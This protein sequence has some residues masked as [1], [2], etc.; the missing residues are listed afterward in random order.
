MTKETGAAAGATSTGQTLAYGAGVVIV[1]LIALFGLGV[2]DGEETTEDSVQNAAQD[3][4]ETTPEV[5]AEQSVESGDATAIAADETVEA[6]AAAGADQQ[7][8]TDAAAQG[9]ADAAEETKDADAEAADSAAADTADTATETTAEEGAEATADMAPEATADEATDA[10]TPPSFDVVRVETDGNMQIAGEAAAG[11]TLEVLLGD[12][13]IHSLIVGDDGKFAAF[14]NLPPSDQ[15]SAMTLQLRQG[16]TVTRSA[17]QVIIAP[18][19]A[20]LVVADA[21]EETAETDATDSIA[22]EGDQEAQ[23]R[24]ADTGAAT[25]AATEESAAKEI[26]VADAAGTEGAIVG[27]ETAGESSTKEDATPAPAEAP[28]APAVIIAGQ[29]GVRVIQPAAEAPEGGLMLDAISYGSAGEVELAGRGIAGALLRVYL[30]NAVVAEGTVGQDTRW[31]LM[32]ADVAPGTYTLRIDQLG[33]DGAVT[34]RVET[35]FKREDASAV[36]AAGATDGAV[37]AVQNNAPVRVVT[38]QPGNT[39]WAIA[40]DAYGD[41]ILYVRVFEANRSLIRNPDLIYPGQIFSV[42]E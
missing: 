30:D 6:G 14:L 15:P 34:A 42:P 8:A 21:D 17:D 38:V 23:G 9:Q 10:Q 41:G 40:R 13:V 27:D 24:D 29:D 4:A 7:P 19:A 2:F 1:V 22:L 28:S 31:S 11:S 32:L 37:G 36:A 18:I 16:D 25:G 20:P 5:T 3:V 39:L 12:T 33:Q 26:A 35:P